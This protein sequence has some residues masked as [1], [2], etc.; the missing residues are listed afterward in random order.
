M[1]FIAAGYLGDHPKVVDTF[2]ER[3]DEVLR[4]DTAMNVSLQIPGSGV[5]SRMW[6][7]PRKAITTT[8]RA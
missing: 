8:W 1:E 6:A 2:R 4:G 7:G 3:V 5:L